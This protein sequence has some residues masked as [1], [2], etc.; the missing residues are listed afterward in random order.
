ML[1]KIEIDIL[2]AMHALELITMFKII[3][4]LN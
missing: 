1:Q 3:T 2:D 4:A